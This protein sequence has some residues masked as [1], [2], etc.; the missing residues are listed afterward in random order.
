MNLDRNVHKNVEF[1]KFLK[2]FNLFQRRKTS[3]GKTNAAL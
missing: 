1:V 3:S 2:K